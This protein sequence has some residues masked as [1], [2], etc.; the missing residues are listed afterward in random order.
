MPDWSKVGNRIGML[1]LATHCACRCLAPTPG[2]HTCAACPTVSQHLHCIMTAYLQIN[3]CVSGVPA[4]L[5]VWLTQALS[6]ALQVGSILGKGGKTVSEI[7][8]NAGCSIRILQPGDMPPCALH[9]D[10]YAQLV[11]V[12]T[13]R[14]TWPSQSVELAQDILPN[15]K[16][17]LLA[18]ISRRR[19]PV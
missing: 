19:W 5:A 8:Q 13:H 4:V 6:A 11:Q 16:H 14:L 12:R 18:F 17:A 2:T 1:S 10:P 7:R 9:A 3:F 15:P